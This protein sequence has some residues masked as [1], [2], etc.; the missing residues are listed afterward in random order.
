MLIVHNA[1]NSAHLSLSTGACQQ[2]NEIYV[3]YPCQFKKALRTSHHINN[4]NVLAERYTGL[5]QSC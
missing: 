2:Q 5:I 1:K 3:M 4:W